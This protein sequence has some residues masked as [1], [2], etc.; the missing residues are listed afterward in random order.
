M[1]V[2]LLSRVVRAREA[3]EDGDVGFAYATLTDLEEDLA[4]EL[5]MPADK[6]PCPDYGLRF[7][8]PGALA[9]HRD[10]A[11]WRAAA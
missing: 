1:S 8:W 11:H 2:D 6:F 7:P 4:G 5:S 9:D 10:N 3:L